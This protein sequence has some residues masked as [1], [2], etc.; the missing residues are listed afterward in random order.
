M[1]ST[2]PA[3]A[4]AIGDGGLRVKAPASSSTVVVGTARRG[5]RQPVDVEIIIPSFNESARLPHTLA[6]SV[7]YLRKQP[8]SSRL[9][10]VDNG[11]VDETAA[12]A[13]AA[14]REASPIEVVVI[15]CSRAG[16]GAA[17]RRGLLTSK[18]P[19]VGFF[20][21]DLSTPL[22]TLDEAVRVLRAGASAAVAS[23]YAPGAHLCIAQPMSRRLGGSAF[24]ALARPLV[25]EIRDTQCGFKFFRLHAVQEVLRRCENSG[26]AFDLEILA[27]LHRAGGI[28]VEIPV[29][30]TDQAG[31]TFRLVHDGLRSFRAVLRL[32]GTFR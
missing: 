20:D 32:R 15:G 18:A 31:S 19:I 26:F 3:R 4:P 12:V 10:V 9:V 22:E 28:I 5:C 6:R 29:D 23:R 1:T 30:W 21:A 25:P 17:V 16:K 27:R 11:S 24:R 2:M 13:R 7:E 14:T 8:W